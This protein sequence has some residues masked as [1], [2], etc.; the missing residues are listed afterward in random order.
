MRANR[1]RAGRAAIAALAGVVLALAACSS[2]G[3][4][5]TEVPAAL[6]APPEG[7]GRIY[8]FR[9]EGPILSA[10]EPAVVVNDQ[11]VGVSHPGDV[12]YRDA[13]PGR[14][15]VF[16]ST[17]A[18]NPVEFTISAGERRYVETAIDWS[19]LD[20]RLTARLVEADE[21]LEAMSPLTL[22]KGLPA[23]AEPAEPAPEGPGG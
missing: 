17:D 14:Y 6:G 16:L 13:R 21:A 7:K 18:E 12:F 23:P 2:P 8:F 15:V 5:V 22:T 11:R 4:P 9:R 1:R 3:P 10:I 20:T 19:V